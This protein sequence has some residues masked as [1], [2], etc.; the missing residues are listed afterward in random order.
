M[1][2]DIPGFRLHNQFLSQTNFTG[3]GAVVAA[4]G[5]VQSQDYAGG[6]WALAQRVK[7]ATTDTA[8]DKAFNDG[9]ILRTHILRPTWHFVAPEDIR[10]MLALS[11]PRVHTASGFMYR[12]QG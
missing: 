6:K 1:A 4:L 8:I 7:N 11:A 5:A 9:K 3:P 10:W 12:Q 2:L